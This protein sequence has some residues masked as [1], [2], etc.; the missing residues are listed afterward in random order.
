MPHHC[1]AALVTCIDD[2]L[3][4]RP[5]GRNHIAEF[6]KDLRIK[7]A[8]I[9]RAGGVQD[10][11]RPEQE[12]FDLSV[13]RDGGVSIKLLNASIIFLINHENCGAYAAMNFSSRDEELKQHYSDLRAA[14]ELLLKEF[15]GKKIKLFFAELEAGTSDVFIIKEVV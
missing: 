8:L 5:E 1:E 3:H 14:K 15:P 4:Q 9:T 12:N 6:I 7:C 2:R 11:V 10:V 13:L